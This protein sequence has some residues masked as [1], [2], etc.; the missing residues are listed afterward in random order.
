MPGS[1]IHSY[2]NLS[3]Q[4]HWKTKLRKVSQEAQQKVKEM[5]NRRF[6]LIRVW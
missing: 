4:K 2:I 3:Q 6:F 1:Y 5:D